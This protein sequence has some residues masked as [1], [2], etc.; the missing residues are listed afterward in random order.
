MAAGIFSPGAV[1]LFYRPRVNVLN[2]PTPPVPGGMPDR[3]GGSPYP[4]G[5]PVPPQNPPPDPYQF[6]SPSRRPSAVDGA[7]VGE[8][9]GGENWYYLGSCVVAPDVE[10]TRVEQ[11]WKADLG[12]PAPF[13]KLFCSERHRVTATLNRLNFRNYNRL[14]EDFIGTGADIVRVFR[15]GTLVLHSHDVEL[16]VRYVLPGAGVLGPDGTARG[17][18]YYS[19][20]LTDFQETTANG[21]VMEASVVFDCLPLFFQRD[22]LFWLYTERDADLPVLKPE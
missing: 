3:P 5:Q 15:S 4:S 19:A 10:A 8:G 17:R 18:L 9:A 22:R 14:R 13:Q 1:D 7:A 16:F 20:T 6:V 11:D 21:R 12:Q 2:P